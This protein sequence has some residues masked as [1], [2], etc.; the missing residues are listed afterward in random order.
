M[1]AYQPLDAPQARCIEAVIARELHLGGQP[2]LGFDSGSPDMHMRRF[3]RTAFIGVEEQLET[4]GAP[5]ATL[6]TATP[7]PSV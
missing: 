1:L 6:A 5:S 2:E 4:I 7:R 3:A